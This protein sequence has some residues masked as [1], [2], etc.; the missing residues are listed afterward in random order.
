MIVPSRPDASSPGPSGPDP[1]SPTGGSCRS[2]DLVAADIWLSCHR[3]SSAT[4]SGGSRAARPAALA[5]YAA[6]PRACAPMWAT[7][8][9]CPAALAAAAADG[10]ASSR[11]AA[12]TTKRRR[13]SSATSSSPRAKAR[14]RTMASRGRVSPGASASNSHSTRSAQ[15]A[16]HP[17]TIRLS[18]SLSVCGEPTPLILPGTQA[19]PRPSFGELLVVEVAHPYASLDWPRLRGQEGPVLFAV[20]RDS[21]RARGE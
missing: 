10:V 18:A 12:P 9:A 16:A 19:G 7:A 3:V 15:S 2:A 11:A 17:A 13:I 4:A 20:E 1:S 8:A 14:V 21:D 6:A 5:A